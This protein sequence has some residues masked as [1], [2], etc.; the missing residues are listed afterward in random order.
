MVEVIVKIKSVVEA[1]G[2]TVSGS[3]VV[4]EIIVNLLPTLT[5]TA[6]LPVPGWKFWLVGFPPESNKQKV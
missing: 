1:A 4:A 6:L 3:V 5:T 2:L